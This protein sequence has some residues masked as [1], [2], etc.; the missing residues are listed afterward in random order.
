MFDDFARREDFT[1]SIDRLHSR[2]KIPEVDA[3]DLPGN[4]KIWCDQV[5]EPN[6][7]KSQIEQKKSCDQILPSRICHRINKVAGGVA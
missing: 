5:P 7:T 1:A 3:T 4:T 2:C 6:A